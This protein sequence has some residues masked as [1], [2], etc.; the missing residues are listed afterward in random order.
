MADTLLKSG[1]PGN[2]PIRFSSA[3]GIKRFA[4][5]LRLLVL[6]SALHGLLPWHMA[7]PVMQVLGGA[8]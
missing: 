2:S 8:K 7:L 4:R 1:T 3:F 6:R 5:L